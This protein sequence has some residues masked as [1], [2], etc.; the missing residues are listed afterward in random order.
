M[1]SIY[2]VRDWIELPIKLSHRDRLWINRLVHNLLVIFVSLLVQHRQSIRHCRNHRCLASKRISNQ[3]K[4]NTHNTHMPLHPSLSHTYLSTHF[5]P[6]NRLYLS[7]VCL[8]PSP[9]FTHSPVLPV[10][11]LLLPIYSSF[12]SLSLHT[13][14]L[15]EFIHSPVFT[16]PPVFAYLPT[17]TLLSLLIHSSSIHLRSSPAHT[18]LP[19]YLSFTRLD[20]HFQFK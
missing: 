14:L 15:P 18:C 8:Y 11:T 16:R 9:T 10:F 12:T 17:F 13:H 7:F 3:H 2:L 1:S 19:V 20:T 4:P 5:C 6:F